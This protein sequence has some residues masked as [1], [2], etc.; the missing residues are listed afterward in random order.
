MTGLCECGCGQQTSIAKRSRSD[1]GWI[2]GQPVPFVWGHNPTVPFFRRLSLFWSR[3]KIVPTTGRPDCI[4]WS[5]V[6]Q[7]NGYGG[8]SGGLLGEKQAHRV[9]YVATFGPI[10]QDR[11]LDHLCRNRLCINPCHLEPVTRK[12]N[13]RR[14]AR[15]KLNFGAAAAIKNSTEPTRVLMRIYGVSRATI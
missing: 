8:Y 1:R 2:K 6:V 7:S 13:S 12:I 15:A 4:E 11:E 10:P 3:T 5:G 9:A 14:G